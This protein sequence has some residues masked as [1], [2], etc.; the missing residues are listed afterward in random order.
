MGTPV[1]T[2]WEPRFRA[3]Q[4]ELKSRTVFQAAGPRACVLNLCVLTLR[5]STPSE[6]YIVPRELAHTCVHVS[7]D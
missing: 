1:F 4:P 5:P 7:C 3:A 2:K 6:K